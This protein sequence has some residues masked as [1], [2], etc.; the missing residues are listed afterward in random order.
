MAL[1]GNT[2]AGW[3]ALTCCALQQA[4]LRMQ[5]LTLADPQSP[6][7]QKENKS[8]SR[9]VNTVKCSS[10]ACSESV[11]KNSWRTVCAYPL[12]SLSIM[13]PFSRLTQNHEITSLARTLTYMFL[14]PTLLPSG[15]TGSRMC[16]GFVP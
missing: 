6:L 9:D 5:A 7:T 14:Q 16:R 10:T 8:S 2:G 3:Q 13:G 1:P 15:T 11:R 4:C 12:S